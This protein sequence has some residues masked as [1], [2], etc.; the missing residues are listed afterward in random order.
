MTSVS[1]SPMIMALD[2]KGPIMDLLQRYF[3]GGVLGDT[4]P[5]KRGGGL[6]SPNI[7]LFP[8]EAKLE[9][10]RGWDLWGRSLGRPVHSSWHPRMK[11][12]EQIVWMAFMLLLIAVERSGGLWR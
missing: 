11:E 8:E 12:H 3:Q 9:G 7:M 1:K 2:N 5:V 10:L 6:I 4:F